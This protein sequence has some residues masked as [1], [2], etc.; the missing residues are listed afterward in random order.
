MEVVPLNAHGSPGGQV[1]FGCG[2]DRIQVESARADCSNERA[3][4]G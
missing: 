1:D 2:D 3:Y 4:I